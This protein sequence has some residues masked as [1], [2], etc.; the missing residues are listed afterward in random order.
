M[1]WKFAGEWRWTAERERKR[2]REG[3]SSTEG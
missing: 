2:K 3:F 1:S